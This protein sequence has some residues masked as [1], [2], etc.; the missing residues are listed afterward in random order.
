VL[1]IHGLN[2]S[3]I[4]SD[5]FISAELLAGHADPDNSRPANVF[6]WAGPITLPH[7]AKL[8]ARALTGNAWSTLSE[9]DFSVGPVAE[10][11]RIT[12]IMYHAQDPNEEFI[13]LRNIGAETINLN[14][15]SF[16]DGIDFTFPNIELAPT[17]NIVLVRD[18]TTFEGR[19]G[20][21]G[22]GSP[23]IAGQYAGKLDN[24]GE[25]IRLEDAAGRT[26][27]DFDYKDG[28]RSITDGEGFSLTATDPAN[29]DPD[30]WDKSDSW[31]AST[32]TG[33]SPGND[34]SD[35]IPDPGTVVINEIMAN[36]NASAS[37]WIEL[38]NTTPTTIDIGGWYLSD[39][40]SN[41]AKYQI[42]AGT[43]LGPNGY[44][45]L[46]QDF[47]FGNASDPG[48]YA[49]FGLSANGEQVY[50]TSTQNGVLTGYRDV[51]DFGASATGVSFGRHYK[52]STDS[53]NFVP[54]S[55][56]TPGSTNANPQIGPIVVSEIMYNPDW[57]VGSAYTND[58]YEYVEL[59]NI[60]AEP[61]T[62]FAQ[63]KGRPW[64]FTDGID[65]T[66]PSELPV[67]IGA[68]DHIL[69]V[70]NLDAFFSRYPRVP[71]RKIFGPYDGKLSNAGE[72]LELAMPGD[73]AGDGKRRYIRIDRVNYSDGF[74]PD[75]SPGSIDLWPAEPDG[76]G[77][78]L[79]RKILDDYGND[80]ENWIAA[81]PS[82]GE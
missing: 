4:D 72:K 40:K 2:S 57:P 68:G 10:N 8:K 32:Y 43:I 49:T 35:G 69:V 60:T 53:H 18:R 64:K 59:H 38:H 61:V 44:L 66:F 79:T 81:S 3:D 82:P 29:P 15:V 58:Q 19:Y 26:I 30:S 56:A 6:Q 25:R 62:L 75:D 37:D 45:V 48:S 20:T 52:P 55:L 50:L 12:E 77:G 39:S 78:S 54:M 16:T 34:D 51:E 74:H 7:S 21:G 76:Y 31:R 73:V 17:R 11:L 36:P 80:P 13:E 33:G 42:A 14:M 47:H 27:L 24:A 23:V 41:L 67:T 22:R 71:A 1:A 63:D 70:K 46:N 5:F 65:F 9:A 28:W